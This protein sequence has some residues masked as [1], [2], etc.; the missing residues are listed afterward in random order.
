MRE[1]RVR[2]LGGQAIVEVFEYDARGGRAPAP[3]RSARARDPA[4]VSAGSTSS[5]WVMQF[6]LVS[7]PEGKAFFRRSVSTSQV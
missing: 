7:Y 4:R 2:R 5:P 6:E 3:G 1:L